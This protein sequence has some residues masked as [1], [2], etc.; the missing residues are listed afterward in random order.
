[1]TALLVAA[2]LLG[3]PAAGAGHPCIRLSR[4]GT[5]AQ[6]DVRVCPGRYRV[7]DPTERGV[8]VVTGSGT[9]LDLTGV[10]IESGDSVPER[11]VGIGVLS[12]GRDSLTIR[13]GRIQGYRFG[14]R[15]RG[16]RGHHL[17]EINL[18]GSRRPAAA[19]PAERPGG[20]GAGLALDSVAGAVVS[21]LVARE[22]HYG[23][24]ITASRSISLTESDLSGN[25]GWGLH[26]WNSSR[27]DLVRNRSSGIL[28]REASDSNVVEG[29]DL[30]GSAHGIVLV[31]RADGTAPSGNLLVRNDVSGVPGEAIG[32][33]GRGNTLLQNR[34]DSGGGIHLS[35]ATGTTVRG[36]TMLGSTGTAV[37]VAGGRENAVRDNV[38]IGGEVGIL[39]SAEGAEEMAPSQAMRFEDNYLARVRRGIVLTWQQGAVVRGNRFDLVDIALAADS[40]SADAEIQG[41][42]FLRAERWFILAPRLTAGGNYWATPDL[43]AARR[44]VQ[45]EVSLEPWFPA[46]AAGF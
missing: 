27:N 32:V 43:A 9:V 38:I 5:R 45:G 40:A 15:V 22:A 17:L 36:N 42:V 39:A 3:S 34:A 11:F 23:V 7:P 2:L 24:V 37:S 41:N 8:I 13:G 25:S 12:A 18:S 10:T 16:G 46:S 33:T 26:L 31:G 19:D 30:T 28:L 6:G 4:P 20:D 35:R 1:M 21:G 29:N 44:R 14:V